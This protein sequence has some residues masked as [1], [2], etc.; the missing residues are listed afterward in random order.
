LS[1][2]TRIA[3]AG[4]IVII[5]ALAFFKLRKPKTPKSKGTPTGG[6]AVYCTNCGTSLSVGSKFCSHCGSAQI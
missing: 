4:V 1:T 2:S 3:V 5:L 6:A